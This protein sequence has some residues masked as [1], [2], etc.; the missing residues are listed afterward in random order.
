M[1]ANPRSIKV[2]ERYRSGMVRLR[3][4]GQAEAKRTWARVRPDDIDGTFNVGVLELTVAAL[5][6]EATRLSSAYLAS[7]LSS[8]LGEEVRPPALM[9]PAGTFND[10]PLRDGLR[11]A[12]IEAKLRI[13]DGM[14]PREAVN[15][16]RATLVNAVG[17]TIDTS[18]R[19]S[20]RPGNGGRRA[21]RGLPAGDSGAPAPPARGWPRARRCRRERRSRSIPSVSAWPNRR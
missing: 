18:A 12:V 4:Q 15:V 8:E 9:V 21:D 20:L 3:R 2:T 10:K 1:P 14:E 7:Y 5:Q 6:K 13:G 17:L 19:E 16:S 11:S